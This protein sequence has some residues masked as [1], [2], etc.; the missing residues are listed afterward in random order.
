[1]HKYYIYSFVFDFIDYEAFDT[2]L[3]IYRILG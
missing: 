1:M 2:F 3:F